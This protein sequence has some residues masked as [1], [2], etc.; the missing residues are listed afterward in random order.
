MKYSFLVL[1]RRNLVLLK[2]GL[3][4]GNN[5]SFLSVVSF[6]FSYTLSTFFYSGKKITK[7][8]L[9]NGNFIYLRT[10][11]SDLEVFIQHYIYKE[12][13][14]LK[15]KSCGKIKYILDAGANIGITALILSELF[16]NSVIVA[17]E[18]EEDNFKMLNINCQG[19][20]K[21][22][23]VIPLLGAFYPHKNVELSIKEHALGEWAYFLTQGISQDTTSNEVKIITYEEVCAL[24]G[25][26]HPDLIKMDIEGSE[27]E[28]FKTT[29]VIKSML[30]NSVLLIEL[31]GFEAYLGYFNLLKQVGI[32][33]GFQIGEFWVT[34][35]EIS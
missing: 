28:F 32:D 1:L 22:N 34:K 26:A 17:I 21:K 16:P 33:N 25:N 5:F 23:Q 24:S 27:I 14:E 29:E 7:I 12:L 15:N 9:K 19:L 20:I 18:L 13:F 4:D 10:R 31:H 2:N 6:S 30:L 35:R 3:I 11:S 8:K